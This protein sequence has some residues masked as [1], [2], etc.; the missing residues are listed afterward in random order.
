MITPRLITAVALLSICAVA[1]DEWEQRW[2]MKRADSSDR[3]HFAIE[4]RR[5]GSRW[6]NSSDVP[7]SRFRK[8]T[9]DMLDRGG[10][11]RFEYVQDAG[12]L[13]CT[14]RFS[15]GRGSGTWT[16][17][18]NWAFVS[19]LRHMGY[20]DAD[21]EQ[22]LS[23]FMHDLTLEFA[24]GVH[25]A[26][27]QA[28][29]KELIEMRTHGVKLEFIR[30]LKANGYNLPVRDIVQ[31]RIHGVGSELI[32]D[33]KAAGYDLSGQQIVQLRIHGVSPEYVR[34]L[35]AFGLHP[36]AADLVQLKIHGVT[37][38]YLK[39]LKDAGYSGLP[40]QDILNLRNHGVSTEFVREA[41]DLGYQF[42]PRELTELRTHGVDGT[43]LRKLR[44]AGMKNLNA[45]QIAKLRIHGVY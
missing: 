14:G 29:L 12:R 8:F 6:M 36:P 2:T 34:D 39:G 40:V 16:F 31:M 1:A 21:E 25:E 43:Y 13:V 3:V 19:G 23:L 7:V 11:A 9:V 18:P 10:D 30:D 15:W 35:R 22:L 38:A 17:T 44:D 42:T 24:H 28:S 5:S 41:R 4:R 45:S 33:L 26:G 20:G 37:T 27:V 32:R